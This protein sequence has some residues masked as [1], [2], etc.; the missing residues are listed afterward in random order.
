MVPTSVLELSIGT[1]M[2][3]DTTKLAEATP[4]V[5]IHLAK[6]AFTPSRE[7]VLSD[8][9]E[10]TFDGYGALHAASAATQ[11]FIDPATGDQIVQCREPAGGWHFVSTGVTG[12][13]ETIYGYY[14][15]DAAGAVLYASEVFDTPVEITASGQ[16]VDIGQVRL[17]L[18]AGSI[19]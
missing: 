6:A 8:L 15:T 19:S 5:A 1:A 11:V 18:P 9:T 12:L 10:A 17:R 4:F 16:G 7:L 14:L 3:A 13:P 2:G